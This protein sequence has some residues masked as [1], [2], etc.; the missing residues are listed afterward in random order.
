MTSLLLGQRT[1]ANQGK[2]GHIPPLCYCN[3]AIAKLDCVFWEG[4][5][6][7]VTLFCCTNSKCMPI[8]F[9]TSPIITFR[10]ALMDTTQVTLVVRGETSPGMFANQKCC[11][12]NRWHLKLLSPEIAPIQEVSIWSLNSCFDQFKVKWLQLLEAVNHW[13]AGPTKRLWL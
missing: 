7:Q 2:R 8:S 12:K 10:F 13:E 4:A 3:R 1:A 9:R 6:I 5:H 11:W